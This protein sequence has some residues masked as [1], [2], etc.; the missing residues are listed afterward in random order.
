MPS[1][2]HRDPGPVGASLDAARTRDAF[3]ELIADGTH[4]ADDTV[5]TM[6]DLVGPRAIVL[7]TDAMAAAGMADGRYQLG[8]QAVVVEDGVATLE[9][10]GAIAGGT[11]R[12]SDIV[13]RL[14]DLGLGASFVVQAAT[15]SPARAA[16]LEIANLDVGQRADLVVA[17]SSLRPVRVMKSGR[18]VS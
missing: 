4:L 16:G 17:D 1:L 10:N 13:R 9:R 3:V 8:P 18:W 11:A 7:V 15:D 2:H 6:F 12:L 5:V 14:V